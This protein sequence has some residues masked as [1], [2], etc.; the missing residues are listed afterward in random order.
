MKIQN[1]FRLGLF[2]GLG[3]LVAVV[4]GAGIGNLATILTYVGAALFLALGVDP[5]VSFLARHKVPR[6]LAIVIV[7]A[8]ILGVFAGFIFAI[9]PVI[10]DQVG[11]LIQQVPDLVA[12][13]TDQTAVQQWWNSTIPWLDYEKV[14]QG[15]EDFFTDNLQAITTGVLSTALTIASGVFGGLIVL[16]LMLYFVASLGSIKR[17]LYQLV[18]ASK[19]EKFI[20]ISEQISTSVGRYVIG[21]VALGLCNG[22]LTFLFLTVLGWILQNQIEYSALLAFIAFLFSLVPL[23]GTITGSIIITLLVWVFD[24]PPAVFVV[25]IWY[26]V[27]MQI[28]AYVLSPNIMNRAVKV[29]GVVVVIAALAGGTLLGI[30]GALVAIPVAASILLIVKQVIIPRQNEL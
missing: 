22:V 29:P 27:Y 15:I 3:V 21:Q 2:G 17:A 9:I 6:S 23:V 5:A 20:D 8:V 1:A 13:L 25:G 26:L 10:A 12:T 14:V 19:R 7:L 18:P 28:E 24:G 11:A 16:I 30:L 4:I